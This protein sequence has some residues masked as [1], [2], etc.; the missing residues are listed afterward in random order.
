ME[1]I[2]STLLE[3][4]R[5][6]TRH[7]AI[8]VSR[9]S[10]RQLVESMLDDFFIRDRER[11]EV[12]VPEDVYMNVDENRITLLLKNLVSNA[13]RYSA[14]EDGPVQ[15]GVR[16]TPTSWEIVVRDHGPGI[17]DDQVEFIGEPFY[18]GDP[19]RTRN[20]GGSGLGLYIVRLVAEAHG[21]SLRLDRSVR[22]GARFVVSLPFE[23]EE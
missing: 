23:P 13:L 11:I 16:T 9:V 20:T 21:G 4:E 17:A 1:R 8:N 5:L 2:I 7:A 12:D 19:S 3:A 15:I 14:A 10:A 18:R 6:N 22:D